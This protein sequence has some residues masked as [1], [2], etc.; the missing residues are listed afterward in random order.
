MGDIVLCDE[1][2]ALLSDTAEYSICDS[3][4]EILE[5]E[6]IAEIVRERLSQPVHSTSM[7]DI[8]LKFGIEKEELE[9]FR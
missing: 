3:C 4:I 9:L 2:G 7:F 6:S 8:A 1:C 5:D